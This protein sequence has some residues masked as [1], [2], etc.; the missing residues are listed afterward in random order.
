M[1]KRTLY[2]FLA[3]AVISAPALMAVGAGTP[4]AAQEASLSIN[5][6]GPAYEVVPAPRPGY[7]WQAGYWRWDHGH[8]YWE[9]GY[10]RDFHRHYWR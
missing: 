4:A 3:A 7:A 8:R 5:L 10:W 9:H 2:T 6:G 1:L